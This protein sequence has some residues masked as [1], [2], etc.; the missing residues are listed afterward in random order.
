[1]YRAS[2]ERANREWLAELEVVADRLDLDTDARSRAADVFLS[3]VGDGDRSKRAT[4]AASL[5]VGA[6]VAGQQ[7]TQQAVADAVGVSRLTVQHHWKDL[8][9]AAGLDPPEW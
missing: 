8:L 6:L 7:R 3:T 9:G 4:L 5:Y 2:D 1:V